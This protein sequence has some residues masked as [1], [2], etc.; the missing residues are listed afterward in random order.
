MFMKYKLL[1]GHIFKMHADIACAFKNDVF[2]IYFI[3][4]LEHLLLTHK[5][6]SHFWYCLSENEMYS[7]VRLS[8]NTYHS[9]VLFL[10]KVL[11]PFQMNI[12]MRTKP[13]HNNVVHKEIKLYYCA[14]IPMCLS[15]T[16]HLLQVAVILF[17]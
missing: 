5:E 16:G 3:C 6:F 8:F 17:V 2:F 13:D 7:Q 14:H 10:K 11:L 12:T 1:R 15:T 9:F 4:N